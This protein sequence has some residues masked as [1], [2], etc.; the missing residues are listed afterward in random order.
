[1]SGLI[2]TIIVGLV[3]GFLA[4]NFMKGKGFGVLGNIVIGILGAIIGSWAFGMVIA[5]LGLIGDIRRAF[6]GAV[7]LIFVVGLFK[8]M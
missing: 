4:G 8:K 3:A 6:A 7:I 5:G 2:Y 1:M